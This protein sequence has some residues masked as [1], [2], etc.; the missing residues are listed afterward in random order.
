LNSSRSQAFM[1][2]FQAH[3]AR[4]LE[5]AALGR[6]SDAESGQWN[7]LVGA[8]Q[9]DYLEHKELLECISTHVVYIGPVGEAVAIKLALQ[10]LMASVV[11]AFASSIALIRASGNDVERFMEFLR[12]SPINAPLFSEIL[13]TLLNRDYDQQ[14]MP[15]RNLE[16]DLKLFLEDADDLGLM[17]HHVESVRELLGFCLA[18]GYQDMDYTAL[19]ELI[20]PP[21]E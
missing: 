9:D 3:Q 19:Y 20:N 1:D 15:S 7:L 14:A 21:R 4:Y 11:S 13:P 12:R 18:R 8:E 17:I 5:I 10:Q 6:L 16:K 2:A